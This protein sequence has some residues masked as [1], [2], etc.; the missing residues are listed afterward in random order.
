[1]ENKFI[2]P[3]L[4]A[5]ELDTK[6]DMLFEILPRDYNTPAMFADI[7]DIPN[8]PDKMK[9][10]IFGYIDS[11][12]IKRLNGRKALSQI[13][14]KLYKDGT[15]IHLHWTT[16]SAKAKAMLY[17]L[18][19][20]APKDT[21]IQ[22]SGKIASY[23]T[24]SGYL[25]KYIDQPM[26]NNIENNESNARLIVPE[27]IYKLK[28]KSKITSLNIQNA[29][30]ELYKNIDSLEREKMLPKII[31]EKLKMTSLDNAIAYT[32]GLKAIP[33]EKFQDFLET[34]IFRRRIL[35]EK[36][37][38]I[39]Y[40]NFH[41][42]QSK[43]ENNDMYVSEE[44][45]KTIQF[46]L[47]RLEFKLTNDQ[48]K[49]VW[50]LL[51]TFAN[52]KSSKNLVFGDVGSGKTM[53]SLII[54]FVLAKVLKEQIVIMTPTSILA[55]QHYEEAVEIIGDLVNV[56]IIHSKTK[57]KEKDTIQKKLDSGE[58]TILYGTSSV[59]GMNYKNLKTIFVDEEQKFGVS[60]K[61]KLH[62][63][64]NTHIVYMTATPIPRTLASSM[65]SDFNIFKIEEKPAMQK[66]RITKVI[67]KLDINEIE[68]IKSKLREGEQILVIVPAIS[69]NDLISSAHAEKK[70]KEL[71]P[72]FKL[73][74]INGRMKPEN[75]EKT[76][77]KFMSGD[78]DILVATTMVDSGFSNKNLS[79]VFI[80]NAERFGI[81][82]MH[83]IRGRVGRGD[84]QGYC[85]LIPA[86]TQLKEKTQDRLN[87]LVESENGFELSMKDIELRGSGDLAGTEQSGSEVNLLEWVNEVEIM[88][89]YLKGESIE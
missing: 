71:F 83:Q 37:W 64:Y 55:K 85:Y 41:S 50:G 66:P 35:I 63:K 79:F 89:K 31:E 30:R 18:K 27:P 46:I 69:S 68:F 13:K 74:K 38:K 58:P 75:I 14:A 59:N 62:K 9:V 22:V 56:E 24:A 4:E 51:N 1:M 45:I 33:I 2:T 44:I 54:A 32:H 53:V 23:E 5:Y 36:I 16:T 47:N 84:K 65:Y 6:E 29:F 25:F 77:E 86:S 40:E 42:K 70:Y 87:S 48:K 57:K 8:L 21:L 7:K 12:E 20:K 15:N 81:A 61:E 43:S 19:M 78:I 26:L 34:D 88:N 49:A 73:D 82:Q 76:T 11:F 10:T 3:V 67:H 17:G 60:D 52:K 28:T 80:E 39:M 72:E